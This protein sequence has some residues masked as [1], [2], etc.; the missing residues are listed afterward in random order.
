MTVSKYRK[1]AVG[2]IVLLAAAV[3]GCTPAAS[4]SSGAA[5]GPSSS[6]VSGGSASAVPSPP[7]ATAATGSGTSGGSSLAAASGACPASGQAIT[8]VRTMDVAGRTRTFIEH[9]PADP[10]GARLTAI[11][12]FPGRGETAAELESYSGLNSI[13]AVVLYLQ[14]LD[15]AGGQSSWE[16]TPY[17]DAAAHDYEF[18]ADVVHLL[19][20]ASC[21]NPARIDMT[22]KSD[23]AG[24]A[25]S[26]ACV[27]PGVAAVA[28][29]S[30]AFY[31][32]DSRCARVGRP[33]SVLNMHGTSDPVIPYDGSVTQGL[34]STDGWIGLWRNRDGC[35]PGGTFTTPATAVTQESWSACRDG[36]A[37]VNDEIVGGG[38]TWPGATAPSG[39]GATNEALDAG[40]AMATFFAAHPLAGTATEQH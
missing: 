31:G 21:V 37:V 26:A 38:H 19:A 28:T 10:G 17:Q 33:I 4:P 9:V 32:S 5:S 27:T 2:A 35:E 40:Q 7:S 18:A 3:A 16:A 13:E 20:D 6:A 8:A 25:A 1:T 23:G 11:I 14:A 29:V 12:A 36:S 34:S 39:P 15:G 30:G 24:F 22:G